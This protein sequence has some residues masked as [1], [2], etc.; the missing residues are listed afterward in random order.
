MT[1]IHN[2]LVFIASWCP[3]RQLKRGKLLV[4]GEQAC[5]CLVGHGLGGN[6]LVLEK[7]IA[8]Y[9]TIVK[10]SSIKQSQTIT[11]TLKNTKIVREIKIAYFEKVILKTFI[12]AEL[13][14]YSSEIQ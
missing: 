12:E 9:G 11:R 13:H 10:H 4:I 1:F 5:E 2:G 3:R 8:I 6:A 7:Q 14:T